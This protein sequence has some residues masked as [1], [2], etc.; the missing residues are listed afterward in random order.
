MGVVES[1]FLFC[2]C[3]SPPSHARL[4][5]ASTTASLDLRMVVRRKRGFARWHVKCAQTQTTTTTTLYL[6]HALMNNAATT[7]KS[8]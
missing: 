3:C 1:F 7:T 6:V 4:E 8:L 5:L 2:S